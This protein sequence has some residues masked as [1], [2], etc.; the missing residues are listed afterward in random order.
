M[1][2][3]YLPEVL[4]GI[5]FLISAQEEKLFFFRVAIN[6]SLHSLSFFR[7]LVMSA[8]EQVVDD[9]SKAQFAWILLQLLMA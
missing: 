1:S 9:E 8:S 4:L 3:S 6:P 7:S 5:V 2:N